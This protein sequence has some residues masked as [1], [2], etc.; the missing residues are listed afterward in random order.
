MLQNNSFFQSRLVAH[1]ALSL[2]M[3]AWASSL[4]ALKIALSN[5]GPFEIMAGRMGV[6]TIFSLPLIPQVWK[7]L[8]NA[9]VRKFLLITI[10]CQPCLY[11]LF[12]AFALRYTSTGQAG[13]ILA[14]TP[15]L[16]AACAYIFLKE[17]VP[18]RSWIGFAISISGVIGLTFSSQ[19]S[20][21]APN[22]MLGNLLEFCAILCGMGYTVCVRYLTRF[23]PSFI[24]TAAMN[25]GGAIFF[26][27]LTMLPLSF[28]PIPLDVTL[29]VWMP[30]ASIIYL[31]TVVTFGG[32]GLYNFGISRL[33]AREASAYTNFLPVI[34]LAM[35]VLWLNEIFVSEQYL[36][37]IC[38][39]IGVLLS[40]GPIKNKNTNA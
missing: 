18:V 36:A 16:V 15:P 1:I 35:G 24:F 19:A 31:G 38:V 12:E 5:F 29:P 6:A 20:Q 11:F 17:Y 4:P 22:P 13:M 27:P 37:S 21:S 34:T 30:M 40:L 26:I 10:F 14:I 23:M 3:V 39:I 7:Q 33:S 32:Y 9:H 2:A 28:T 8:Q 25:I